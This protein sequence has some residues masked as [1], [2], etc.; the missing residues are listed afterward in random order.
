MNTMKLPS[1]NDIASW[2]RIALDSASLWM[3]ASTVMWLRTIRIASGGKIAERE[4][5]RMI[6]EKLL[7]SWE[8][9]WKLMGAG[10]AAPQATAQRSIDHYR[11]KVRA[12]RRR[13]GG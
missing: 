13:L 3:E 4:A 7:A 1:Y 2:N 12:N 6:T 8:L 11:G 9:G 10:N 5:E